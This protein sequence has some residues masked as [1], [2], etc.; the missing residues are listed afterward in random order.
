MS[1]GVWVCGTDTGVGKTMVS[2]GLVRALAV[3]GCRVVGLKPVVSGAL[4]CSAPPLGAVAGGDGSGAP[5]AGVPG[6]WEDLLRLEVAGGVPL[7]DRQRAV[8]RLQCPAAPSF[9]ARMEGL[10]IEPARLL[11]EVRVGMSL[12]EF[13]VVEGVGGVRVPLA[14]GYDT[15]DFTQALGLPAILVVGVRLGCINHALLSGEALAARGIPLAAWVANL[16]VEPGYTLVDDTL[17]AIGEGLGMACG[18]VLPRLP[19]AQSSEGG[20]SDGAW[21]AQVELQVAASAAALGGLVSALWRT[22]AGDGHPP[23][24][25]FDGPGRV[26]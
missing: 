16:G 25:E 19:G 6:Q 24:D 4:G 11:A 14:P 2:S 20:R 23:R 13:A 1:R 12:G 21:L 26:A 17:A 9:A 3:R 22:G 8:Y 10:S 15:A 7:R 5:A 18:A